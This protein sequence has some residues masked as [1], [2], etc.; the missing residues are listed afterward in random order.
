M[1]TQLHVVTYISVM[2]WQW[3]MNYI[4]TYLVCI[5]SPPGKHKQGT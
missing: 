2:I 3:N 4:N 1:Q 5:F